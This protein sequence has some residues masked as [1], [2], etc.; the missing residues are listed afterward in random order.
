MSGFLGRLF[1]AWAGPDAKIKRAIAFIQGAEFNEARWV[2]EDLDHPEAPALMVEAK[3]GL[4]G[5]N[6]AEAQAQYAAGD[7]IGG[8]AHLALA[9]EFGATS[10][11]CRVARRLGRADAPA[12]KVEAPPPVEQVGDDPLWSLPPEDPRLRYAVLVESYPED[13]RERLIELGPDFATAVL[14]I[15]DGHAADAQKGLTAFIEQDPVVRY[16]RA[17]AALAA[18][19]LPAAASDL[20]TFGD[21]LGHR[22]IGAT[23][24]A[25]LLGQV[26]LSLHRAEEALEPI[27]NCRKQTTNPGDQH[28]LDAMR[29][30]LLTSLGRLDEADT[31]ATHLVRTAPRDMG[32][33]RLLAQIRIAKGERGQ[34]MGI[35]EDGLN[36]CCSSPGKC[37]NQPLDILA[38]RALARLYLEDRIEPDRSRELLS[39]LS[40]HVQEPGWEDRYVA[41]LSARNEGQP[42][43]TDMV[44]RLRVNLAPK[45]RRHQLLSKAFSDIPTPSEPIRE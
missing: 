38:V 21:A 1:P 29:A 26:L 23:H 5:A 15:D 28:A 20:L 16:E 30:H 44:Q 8:E 31:L 6:L 36:R 35:L 22:R 25:V 34:A 43:L 18:G 39:D 27:K 33:T 4:V 9:R 12:P 37:G 2:L 32:V 7:R 14:K 17:R 45:D 13:L 19:Q 42:H 3:A 41:A 40:R 11:Q 10:E 24:T